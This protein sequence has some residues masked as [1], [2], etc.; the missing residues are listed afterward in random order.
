MAQRALAHHFLVLLALGILA[1]WTPQAEAHRGRHSGGAFEGR[2]FRCADITVPAA[3]SGCGTDPLAVG[4]LE[5]EFGK[6]RIII[7]GAARDASYTVVL[8]APDGGP[9]TTLG[10]VTTN[11]GGHGQIH[12]RVFEQG[13]VASGFV[14]LRRNGLDQFVMG[15]RLVG[16]G[17]FRHD[18]GPG[19]GLANDAEG[20]DEEEF[21]A[22]LV[23]CSDVGIPGAL[24]DC[25][26]DR[27]QEGVAELEKHGGFEVEVKRAVAD[28]I[29]DVVLR[30]LRGAD[31]PLGTL[32]TDAA[33]D[34][35]VER[36]GVFP[37]PGVA[38]GL[39]VLR[40]DGA[41][42]FVQGT[43]V[44]A[45]AAVLPASR[46]VRVGVTATAFA[47]VINVG[48][49]AA[50]DCR[51]VL[52]SDLPVTF[53]FQTTD[54]TTNQPTGTPNEPVDIPAGGAQSFV[55]AFT[56]TAPFRARD[57]ELSFVCA[58]TAPA[59]IARGLNTLL[60]SASATAVPD[61]I[62]LTATVDNDGIITIPGTHG[63]G[64]FA[65]A[66]ANVG[67]AG[68]ITVSTHTGGVA[69]PVSV[70]VCQ[71]NA[72]G[73]CLDEPRTALTV[74]VG[75]GA[76]LSFGLFVTGHGVV[77]FDPAN[78]RIFVQFV[79]ETGEIRGSTSVAVRTK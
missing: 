70:K 62:G 36:E 46:S 52:V 48:P 51:I 2:L 61:T 59:V 6:L 42:Q 60:L 12:A 18:S 15:V 72:A 10:T 78:H 22:R 53:T 28:T 69:L 68:R 13:D 14:V 4:L 32:T 39:I 24:T 56:P 21:E 64:V 44:H 63:T 5:I 33:G 11:H 73:R 76:F 38:S 67:I 49:S 66:I 45:L 30:P 26:S 55:V 19:S 47:T 29:Y 20:D 31:L 50:I 57:V 17:R 1:V 23:R 75:E 77:A 25:G 43:R 65:V 58:N 35:R 8:Q 16:G 74:D 3:L 54:P 34:G 40:R 7:N 9:D 71:T 41:D 37:P 27:L 79:D